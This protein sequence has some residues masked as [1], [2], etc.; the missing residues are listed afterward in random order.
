MDLAFY[1]QIL[2]DEDIVLEDVK[3]SNLVFT[4]ES[5]SDDD[6][7]VIEDAKLSD[8]KVSQG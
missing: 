1:S 8:V 7:I 4:P 5:F 6:N 3:P 2:S